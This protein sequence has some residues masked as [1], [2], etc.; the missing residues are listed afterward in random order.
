MSDPGAAPPANLTSYTI[1]AAFN[2]TAADISGVNVYQASTIIGF[3]IPNPKMPDFGLAFGGGTDGKHV[4][5]GLGAASADQSITSA[6]IS[7]N[8]THSAVLSSE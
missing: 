2:P 1:A 8:Q 7:L 5:G 6:S 3:D 4:I